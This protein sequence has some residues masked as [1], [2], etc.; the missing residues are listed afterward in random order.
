MTRLA[1]PAFWK[2]LSSGTIIIHQALR[3]LHCCGP[4]TRSLGYMAFRFK[5]SPSLL[6]PFKCSFSTVPVSLHPLGCCFPIHHYTSIY[7]TWPSDC[8]ECFLSN[9]LGSCRG[10]EELCIGSIYSTVPT[11]LT[12]CT[13][14]MYIST[15]IKYLVL[16]ICNGTEQ[17]RIHLN[18]KVF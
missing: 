11:T 3:K 12:T 13:T 2:C 8:G 1:Q 5:I 9:T 10:Q 6:Y 16:F 7:L 15:R 14:I 18:S 4:S 17:Q